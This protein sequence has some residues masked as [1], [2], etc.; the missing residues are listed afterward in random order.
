MSLARMNDKQKAIVASQ[1]N[2]IRKVIID[3][4]KTLLDE[5]SQ[6]EHQVVAFLDHYY[7]TKPKSTTAFTNIYKKF[8]TFEKRFDELQKI[9]NM[10]ED[11][12][13]ALNIEKKDQEQLSC[14]ILRDL[15]SSQK[16]RLLEP[17]TELL[18]GTSMIGEPASS[19]TAAKI[20]ETTLGDCLRLANEEYNFAKSESDLEKVEAYT[21]LIKALISKSETMLNDQTI[22]AMFE[23]PNTS[24]A[25]QIKR[26]RSLFFRIKKADTQN[27]LLSERNKDLTSTIADLTTNKADDDNTVY[28]DKCKKVKKCLAACLADVAKNQKELISISKKTK[29]GATIIASALQSTQKNLDI[30]RTNIQEN[31]AKI[32]AL[33]EAHHKKEAALIDASHKAAHD[34]NEKRTHIY[35]QFTIAVKQYI[36]DQK[37]NHKAKYQLDKLRFKLFKRKSSSLQR[38]EKLDGLKQNFEAY[39]KGK[40][41][42]ELFKTD[43]MAASSL[44]KVKKYG[45]SSS[46]TLFAKALNNARRITHSDEKPLGFKAK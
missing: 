46:H 25:D 33:I 31:Q 14:N 24:L 30:I 37:K 19:V 23:K 5:I 15:I 1:C 28:L 9:N 38:A 27:G 41:S 3:Q 8:L 7:P 29:S 2:D 13:I 45:K 22:V 39:V 11:I 36:T 21:T 4:H 20:F 40:R 42:A 16:R 35:T 12:F 32:D 17:A 6:Y 34:V 43:V 44:F 10:I 18:A 26:I